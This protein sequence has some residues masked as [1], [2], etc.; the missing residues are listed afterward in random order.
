MRPL[1]Q[2]EMMIMYS[3]K[4][5]HLKTQL[6]SNFAFFQTYGKSKVIFFHSLNFRACYW[7][8]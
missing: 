6:D 7:Q 1:A 4:N 2:R 5:S 8:G 3:V